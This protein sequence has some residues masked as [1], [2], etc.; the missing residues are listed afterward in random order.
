VPPRF[1]YWTILAGGLPTAFRAANRDEL[2]PTF[3]RLRDKHPDAVM[4]WFARGKLWDSPD[5]AR[6]AYEKRLPPDRRRERG[7]P[8]AGSQETRGRDWRPGGDHRDPRQKYADAKKAR[9]AARRKQRFE[10]KQGGVG[11]GDDT[12]PFQK[13]QTAYRNQRPPRHVRDRERPVGPESKWEK[14]PRGAS[15]ERPNIEGERR[16]FEKPAFARS[17]HGVKPSRPGRAVH[18]PRDGSGDAPGGKHSSEPKHSPQRPRPR[19]QQ[20]DRRFRRQ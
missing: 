11:R 19:P 12:R 6:A 13:P 8:G 15:T 9:N 3:Q 16:P 10:R 1:A 17:G 2:M 5:D 7:R 20:R 14:R 4:K 18:E